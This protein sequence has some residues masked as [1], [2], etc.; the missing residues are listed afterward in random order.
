MRRLTSFLSRNKGF[1]AFMLCMIMFRSALADWNVVPTGS[2]QPTIQ[3]GD[4]ILVDKA[5]YDIRLPLTHISLLHLAD[6]RRGD[7]VVL[8]SHAANER[9]V[10]RVIGI[11]GDEVAMRSNVLYINGVAARY[12]P[13]LVQGIHDDQRDPARYAVEQ[14]DGMQHLVRLSRYHPSEVRDFGPVTVP[15]GKYLLLGDNRDNSEDSR[16]L[17]FFPRDEIV[18]RSRYVAMSL[19]PD[20]HYLPRE[21]RF[22]ARLDGYNGAGS[23]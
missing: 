23:R 9:L 10:K 4:R 6:P 11:P 12:T 22:A 17:G 21:R 13:T 20:N 2:M 7:I 14:V 15:P 1:I 3:I 16:Y 8:D 19:D 18:G 5:A